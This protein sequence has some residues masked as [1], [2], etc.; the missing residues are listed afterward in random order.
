[1]ERDREERDERERRRVRWGEPE[2]P[3][4]RQVYR[5]REDSFE[6]YTDAKFKEMFV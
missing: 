2:V 3:R 6:S 5:P 1:M 4:E